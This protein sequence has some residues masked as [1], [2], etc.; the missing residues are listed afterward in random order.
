MESIFVSRL[1]Y[2]GLIE[3][4]PNW[5]ET[6]WLRYSRR[7]NVSGVRVRGSHSMLVDLLHRMRQVSESF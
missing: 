1:M 5:M 7:W 6:H 4:F 2:D 3:L